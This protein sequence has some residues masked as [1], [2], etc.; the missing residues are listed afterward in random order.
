MGIKAMQ[1]LFFFVVLLKPV[2]DQ[3]F[4]LYRFLNIENYNVGI[5]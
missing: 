1:W 5:H 2:C 3:K 4:I